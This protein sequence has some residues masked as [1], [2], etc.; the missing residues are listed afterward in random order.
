[1]REAIMWIKNYRESYFQL[2]KS[3]FEE[4]IKLLAPKSYKKAVETAVK[5]VNRKAY[6]N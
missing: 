1:M 3:K 2:Y 5:E 4:M 6:G